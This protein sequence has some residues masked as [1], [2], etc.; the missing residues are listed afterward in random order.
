MFFCLNMDLKLLPV[1][2]PF[3]GHHERDADLFVLVR[4]EGWRGEGT[5]GAARQPPGGCP[6]RCQR[7]VWWHFRIDRHCRKVY[8]HPLHFL[9]VSRKQRVPGVRKDEHEEGKLN[10]CL[11]QNGYGKFEKIDGCQR[12]S[13]T[14]HTS[15]QTNP[16]WA[17]GL[18]ETGLHNATPKAVQND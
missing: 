4:L 8:F 3:V 5:T 16:C 2:V 9:N 14:K 13:I 6:N 10:V 12:P 18:G 17:A 7:C 1:A 15:Q 11:I